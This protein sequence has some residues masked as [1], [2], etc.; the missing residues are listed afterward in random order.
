MCELS[1]KVAVTDFGYSHERKI[2]AM[3]CLGPRIAMMM[4][5]MWINGS[6][7]VVNKNGYTMTKGRQRISKIALHRNSIFIVRAS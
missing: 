7:S 6:S 5:M 4:M 1:L 3:S 2:Q